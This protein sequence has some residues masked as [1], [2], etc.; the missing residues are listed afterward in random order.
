M[1]SQMQKHEPRMVQ[2]WLASLYVET[3][4]W[5]ALGVVLFRWF[6]AEAQVSRTNESPEKN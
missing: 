4:L 1:L 6:G 3:V 5:A 2:G